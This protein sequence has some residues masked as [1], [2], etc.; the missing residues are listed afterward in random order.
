MRLNTAPT[1][2]SGQ[3]PVLT[4]QNEDSGVPSGA[5]GTLISSL[6]DFATPSGQVDNVTDPD[7]GA[8]L[9][10][11][12][13]ATNTSNG[14][15]W[16]STNNGSSWN[17]LGAVSDAAARLLAADANTRIYFQSNANYNG[18]IAD[19]ITF[20]AWDQ[21]TGTNG[22]L[23]DTA[24]NGG[25][26]AFSTVTDT[27]SL[28]VNAVNDTPTFQAGPGY[29]TTVFPG[30]TASNFDDVQVMADGRTVAV[31]YVDTAGGRETVVARY[32]AD[33]S[34][35]TSFNGVGYVITPIVA[36][37]D[38]ARG[39]HVFSDGKILVVGSALDT[40]FDIYLAKYNANGTLDT[41]F[42]GGDGVEIWG[43]VSVNPKSMTVLNDGKILVAG[44]SNSNFLLARFN[45]NGSIDSTFG[46]GGYVT[47]DFA[48][49]TDWAE[50]LKVQADGKIV[51]VGRT[52]NGTSF[53]VGVVRYLA[54]GTLDSSFGSGGKVSTD[55]GTS[56]ADYGT[57]I[58]L[59]SD[60]KLVVAGWGNAAGT[61]DFYVLRYNTNGT[62]DASFGTGGVST[63]AIGT[64]GSLSDFALDVAV[65]S[66]GKI[67]ATGYSSNQGN[68][69]SVIRLNSNGSLDGTFGS[70]G[71]VDV[72]FGGSSMDRAS[73]L[74]IH[75]STVVVA[76][77]S[78]QP[79]TIAAALLRLDDRGMLDTQLKP[80][81]TLGGT[82]GYVEGSPAI[83]LDPDAKIFD[84]E[85]NAIDNYA[86]A[87]LTI[88]RNG[89]A[90]AQDV[91]SATGT[92]SPLTHGGKP[93]S[94][95][96]SPSARSRPIA[97]ERWC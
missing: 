52:F 73:A 3:S 17:A 33:G 23:V 66:D 28:V 83:V 9:G 76:G 1:L 94:W 39:V 95:V 43:P 63:T 78:N 57:A 68:N 97:A 21:T 50:D 54:D 96:E 69:F 29:L 27:A 8:L 89:G 91:Y 10:I 70:G 24:T 77:L 87:T 38:E 75:G 55:V 12:I 19:A 15:W 40:G 86:N 62:L 34:L 36:S 4:S 49:G 41:S 16:Y 11:A 44:D 67:Y 58:D 85:L 93:A 42:G 6:V 84:L 31:G 48:G 20:R 13:T 18:T 82:V 80:V 35:D 64:S 72:N 22:T 60:G 65:R 61:T 2:D 88:L 5:V 53:D 26:T 59:Q 90:N 45:A 47:T 14:T 79:G 7:S 92:L 74:A 56:S 51:L 25:T 30:T 71:I 32:L 81:D 37:T 46:S